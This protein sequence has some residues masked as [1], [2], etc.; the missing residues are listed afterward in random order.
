MGRGAE[1]RLAVAVERGGGE[2]ERRGGGAEQRLA[3]A[4]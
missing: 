3:V 1:Q 2:G 4:V